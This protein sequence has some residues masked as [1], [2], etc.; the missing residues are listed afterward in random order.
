MPEFERVSAADAND[1]VQAYNPTPPHLNPTDEELAAEELGG[2]Q[3]F[4][5]L[6]DDD[7]PTPPVTDDQTPTP[8]PPP[9]PDDPQDPPDK[10]PIDRDNP[11]GGPMP[12]ATP[13]LDRTLRK[14]DPNPYG[15]PDPGDPPQS[16]ILGLG[17]ERE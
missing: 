4:R 8:P 10:R 3:E 12:P 14:L 17:L 11:Y 9:G 15:P 2:R 13:P 5:K 6:A 1:S 7:E 16:E